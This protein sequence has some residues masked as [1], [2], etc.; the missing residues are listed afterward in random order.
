MNMSIPAVESAHL[1][2]KPYEPEEHY[3]T[4]SFP[5]DKGKLFTKPEMN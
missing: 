5:T 1:D 2:N 4:L 3:S